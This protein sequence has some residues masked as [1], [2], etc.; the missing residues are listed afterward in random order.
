[1]V[2]N[3]VVYFFQI[4]CVEKRLRVRATHNFVIWVQAIQQVQGFLISKSERGCE[5]KPHDL[6]TGLQLLVYRHHPNIEVLH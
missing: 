5:E 1:M 6:H 3:N 4:K 2:T